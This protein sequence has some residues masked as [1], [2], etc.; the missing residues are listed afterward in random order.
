M[1]PYIII[2]ANLTGLCCAIALSHL[3]QTSILVDRKAIG[4]PS[5]KD[6]R[7]IALSYGSKQI[8]ESIDLWDSLEP[9]AGKIDEIRVTDQHSPLFLHFNNESTLGYIIESDDIQNIM[10]E[11]VS[12][13]KNITIMGST[14]YELIENNE[15]EVTIKLNETI[16]KTKL[17]IAADGKFSALRKLCNI[18]T[19]EHDYKQTAIVCKVQHQ[20]SHNN[21]AQEI[22]LKNGPF[23]ILPLKDSYQ[24]GIVWTETPE[25]AKILLEQSSETFNY[26]LTEKFTDYLGNIE[27]SG[28]SVSYPLKLIMAKKYFNNRIMLVGDSAHSIHPISGQGFNLAIQDITCLSN[29]YKKY[30]T[31]GLEPGCFQ[32]LNEYQNIRMKDNISMAVITD[33]LNKLFSNNIPFIKDIRKIGLS[34]VN[35]IP[36]LQK[37]FMEYAMKKIK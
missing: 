25:I 19:F 24:S 30:S 18:D 11:H 22:F 32:S 17:L 26:F 6:T 1:Q 29:L 36:P 3:G 16:H 23:A 28:T 31:I 27:L 4:K 34:L 5:Y 7:A 12:K 35:Q 21:I 8:L 20:K 13:D 15:H 9:Y 14:T 37:Y 10:Y 33:G 2:G